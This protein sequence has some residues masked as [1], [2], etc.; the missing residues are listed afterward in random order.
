MHGFSDDFHPS[1]G[2]GQVGE[3]P[4]HTAAWQRL[5]CSRKRQRRGTKSPDHIQVSPPNDMMPKQA[6]LIYDGWS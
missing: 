6:A 5:L 4:T 3:T 2:E 1:E